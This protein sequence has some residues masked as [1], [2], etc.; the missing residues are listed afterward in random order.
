MHNSFKVERGKEMF[1][2]QFAMT[3]YIHAVF[4]AQ[5]VGE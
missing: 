4:K 1:I 5:Y 2:Q 3:F